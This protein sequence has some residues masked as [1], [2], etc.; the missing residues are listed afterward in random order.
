MRVLPF[1]I[2][3]LILDICLN[4]F[5]GY[6][7]AS[8]PG[9]YQPTAEFLKLPGGWKLK[10]CS[11]FDVNR[12]GEIFLLHRGLHPIICFDAAGNFLRSWGDDLIKTAHGLRVDR[13][14]KV[15]V[16]DIGNH[17]VFKFEPT[18]KLLLALGTGQPG[19][20]SDQ[21]NKP[22]DI[23]FGPDGEVYVSDGYGNDRVMKFTAK[24]TFI[25]SWGSTGTAPGEFDLPHAIIVDARGR[26]LVGDR[27]N[28]RIQ[29]FDREG[30]YLETWP[31]FAPFGMAFR[32]DGTLFVATGREHDVICL[33]MS[34]RIQRRWGSKGTAPGQFDFPHMLCFDSAGALYVAEVD[35][36]RLQKFISK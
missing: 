26:I 20:Q 1:S 13:D 9:D 3:L 30:T 31:G 4:C 17:R 24:G 12:K 29:V 23:A 2:A 33:D 8:E 11:A 5:A 10:D 6:A 21:F 34:G 16:T 18:G 27:E 7:R 36:N 19:D 14:Q 25:K 35:G 15:W 22:T 28:D 32:P